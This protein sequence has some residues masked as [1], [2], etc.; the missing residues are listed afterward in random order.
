MPLINPPGRRRPGLPQPDNSDKV[1]TA[2]DVKHYTVA[3]GDTINSI[4][5]KFN[6]LPE[7]L[8]GF[9][10]IFDVEEALAPGRVLN[11]PPVDAMYYVAVKGDTVATVSRSLPGRPSKRG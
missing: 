3:A 2:A 7:T 1:P 8:M 11:V 5:D 9:N 4:A 6:I 10:G